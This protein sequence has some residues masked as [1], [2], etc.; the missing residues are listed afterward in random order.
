MLTS[1]EVEK[2]QDFLKWMEEKFA[3]NLMSDRAK[4]I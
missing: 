1:I 2:V 3:L 4:G